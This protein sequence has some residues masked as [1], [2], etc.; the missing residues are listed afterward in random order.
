MPEFSVDLALLQTLTAIPGVSG[1]EQPVAEFIQK[2]LPREFDCAIDG[3]GNLT[4]HLPGS[5]PKLV[6][7]THMDEV[8]LI[9]QQIKPNG[10]LSVE[11]IGGIS[12]RALPGSRMDLW[13]ETGKLPAQIG[14]L[15]GHLDKGDP[16]KL[17][18]LYVDI[19]AR[20]AQ[21]AAE[22][23]V[24]IGDV[25]TWPHQFQQTSP[26]RVSCK[27]LD[28]R[29]GCF[30]LMLLAQRVSNLQL[31]VDLTLAFSVQEENM[32][33][34]SL[35]IMRRIEPDIVIGID[36]TLVFDTPDLDHQQSGIQLGCGPVLKWMDA[37][38]GKLAAYLPD[39]RLSRQIRRL[40]I[41]HN[42]PLQQEVMTGLTT[43]ITPVPYQANGI[44]TA[45]LSLPIRYH[46][47]PIESA[48]LDDL[49][50]LI[51]LVQL[52]ILENSL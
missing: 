27:A 10:F 35:P 17:E 16:P 48:D 50:V 6:L 38:R 29:L 20:S 18:S 28:D 5:G 11:R 36:G 13:T 41:N 4:A 23:G 25:L 7:L 12:I 9:V 52:V 33:S 22:M 26:N 43:A 46:H 45:A 47:T 32:L 24:Q 1:R 19:G 34:G 15:P 49:A 37:I 30:A 3:L 42:L 40:A 14:L 44:R 21:Q 51:D 8:G 39:L 31:N 2:N